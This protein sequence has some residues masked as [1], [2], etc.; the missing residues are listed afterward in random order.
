MMSEK[1]ILQDGWITVKPN[2]EENKGSKVLISSS[3]VI[4]AGMGGKFNGKKIS[5][6]GKKKESVKL[7]EG[8][9]KLSTPIPAS[10]DDWGEYSTKYGTLDKRQVTVKNGRI[11]GMR[12]KI[13][14]NL[15]L[16]TEGDVQP[17]SEKTISSEK[18]KKEK[19]E[20]EEL[21]RSR[22]AKAAVLSLT[23]GK[24]L[25]KISPE[26]V[27]VSRVFKRNTG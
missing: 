11:V 15:N 18:I 13:A 12:E 21:R 9:I 14:Q 26:K 6:V 24:R 2:G 25:A 27:G 10:K 22:S 1:Q 8:H 17:K 23:A 4:Q 7:K 5:S 3:G 20:A 16:K 19:A